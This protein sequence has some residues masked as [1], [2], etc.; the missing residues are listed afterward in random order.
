[1]IRLTE[2]IYDYVIAKT[3]GKYD[4]TY[5]GQEVNLKPPYRKLTMVDAVKEYAG[6]DFAAADNGQALKEIADRLKKAGLE[7]RTAGAGESCYLPHLT[8]LLKAS[9]YNPHSYTITP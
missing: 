8:G 9:L 6:M 2:S 4:I 1:M 5:Q 3:I 7:L